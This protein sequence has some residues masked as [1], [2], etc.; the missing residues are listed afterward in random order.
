MMEKSRHLV[1]LHFSQLFVYNF[2]AYRR[3]LPPPP[4]LLR[5][6]APSNENSDSNDEEIE[7]INRENVVTGHPPHSHH[8]PESH[9]RDILDMNHRLHQISQDEVCFRIHTVETLGIHSSHSV[10]ISW[11]FYHSDFT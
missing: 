1:C 2:Q 10:E 6:A 4:P 3:S 7:E 5:R 8:V 11:F 9:P